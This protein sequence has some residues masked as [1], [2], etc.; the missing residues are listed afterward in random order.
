MKE[1]KNGGC[2]SA[3]TIVI[4]V[5]S[6]KDERNITQPIRITREPVT[7]MT[8]WNHFRPSQIS[9]YQSNIN[10]KRLKIATIGP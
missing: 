10:K 4:L 5:T 7:R 2:L 9:I 1:H 6:R 8:K 3:V